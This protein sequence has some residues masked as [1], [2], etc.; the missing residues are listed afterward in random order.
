[1]KELDQIMESEAPDVEKL[2]QA[3]KAVMRFYAESGKQEVELLRALGDK[4]KLVCAQVKLSTLEHANAVLDHCYL[5]V[6]GKK[7]WDE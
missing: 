6:T 3:F 7:V 1:M 5:L 4:Q 2:A